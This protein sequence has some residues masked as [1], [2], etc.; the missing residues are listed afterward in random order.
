MNR[1]A[2]CSIKSKAFSK[3][4]FRIIISFFY[5]GDRDEDTPKTKPNNL[6]LSL[7][8]NFSES[9]TESLSAVYWLRLL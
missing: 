2:E 7:N 4:N 8:I 1:M 5:F 9:A 6:G 3:S